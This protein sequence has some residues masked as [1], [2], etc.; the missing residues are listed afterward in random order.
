[1]LT[2]IITE[3][4][5][6][7][8]RNLTLAINPSNIQTNKTVMKAL[9]PHFTIIKVSFSQIACR[10]TFIRI[11]YKYSRNVIHTYTKMT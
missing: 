6:V 5:H 1:M 8:L 9:A 3:E 7:L 4:L 11:C 2:C 10:S